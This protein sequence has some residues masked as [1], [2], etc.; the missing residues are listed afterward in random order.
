MNSKLYNLIVYSL[1]YIIILMNC[2]CQSISYD[3]NDTFALAGNNRIMFEKVLNHYKGETKKYKA[4]CFLISN[5]RWHYTTIQV[6]SMDTTIIVYHQKYDSLYYTII[7]DYKDEQLED[8]TIRYQLKELN[9][10]AF[11]Q[12]EG[13]IIKAPK[14]SFSF[15]W[16][17]EHLSADFIIQ[18]IDNAFEVW[19]KGPLCQHLS[20]NEF[21]ECILPY[22]SIQTISFF[23]NGRFL[24]ELMFKHLEKTN[25]KKL[26]GYLKRYNHYVSSMQ[27]FFS[28]PPLNSHIGFYDLFIGQDVNCINTANNAC[29]ILRAC[30]IPLM[31]NFNTAYKEL[32][33]RHY[34]CSFL[35]DN[36]KWRHFNPQTNCLDTIEPLQGESLN[37]IRN[38]YAAQSDSPYFIKSSNELVPTDFDSPCIKDVTSSYYETVKIELPFE[39]E[40]D[41]NLAYL[42]AFNNNPS[43]LLP[44]CW[45]KIDHER[46]KVGYINA[47]YNTLY[48]PAFFRGNEIVYFSYP[49]Y[50]QKDSLCAG[51][52]KI[53]SFPPISSSQST[54]DIIV[55]RKYPRKRKM[56]DIA[57]KMIGGKFYGANCDNFSDSVLLYTISH[58]PQP[59]LQDFKISE[60][61]SFKYFKYVSPTTNRRSNIS[62]LEFLIDSTFYY[63]YT[64]P[65]SPLPIMDNAD[66][67]CPYRKQ[68]QVIEKNIYDFKSQRMFDQNMQTAS[69]QPDIYLRLESPVRVKTIRMAPLNAENS[70]IPG[71]RY[72]LL[73]W[74]NRWIE[75]DW[76]TA[77]YNYLKFK[78]I[79][80]NKI[81]WLKNLDQGIEELPF[82]YK[83]GKAIVYIS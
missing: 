15:V 70:I 77:E 42:Y 30:G 81:Y 66:T 59:Y 2:N 75:I 41:N 58:E 49:F 1:I 56:I 17:V 45:G 8:S 19:Q 29:N 37:I 61:R 74:D 5:M 78:N 11:K 72:K 18:H 6:S 43:G 4:A 31:V 51:H 48:F 14:L 3:L 64:E 7:K 79:P 69:S 32:K 20:F 68:L 10:K 55:S 57:Q 24:N 21:C 67:L 34:F 53:V 76:I 38:T 65:A 63:P 44:V 73:Y 28:F 54:G 35:D 9:Y 47:M 26:S 27:S 13:I 52:Y 46:N 83:N 22:R 33:G 40:S 39:E 12:N 80:L 16:D 82:I 71:N 25:H 62:W 50:I 36:K 60:P 23:E